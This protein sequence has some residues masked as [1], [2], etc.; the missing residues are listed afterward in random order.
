MQFQL[1]LA[2][3]KHVVAEGKD[4]ED[5]SRRYVDRNRDAAVSAWRTWL[6]HG[7]F[8]GVAPGQIIG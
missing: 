7:L 5:A 3:G 4:G 2:D 6:R 1:L 8:V